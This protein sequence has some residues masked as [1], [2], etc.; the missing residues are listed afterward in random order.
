MYK[1]KGKLRYHVELNKKEGNNMEND[2]EMAALDRQ[3]E[4]EIA[5]SKGLKE[6]KKE[7]AFEKIEID[8]NTV[9]KGQHIMPA[10]SKTN[11]KL[12]KL[13]TM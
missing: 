4:L 13:S 12:I 10:H 3:V 6:K 7:I 11:N 5:Q 2:A 8:P 9:P 1:H